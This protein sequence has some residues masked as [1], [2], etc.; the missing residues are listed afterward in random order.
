MTKM[1]LVTLADITNLHGYV[2]KILTRN[3]QKQ[4][5]KRLA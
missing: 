4:L 5:D 3:P 1:N 2:E